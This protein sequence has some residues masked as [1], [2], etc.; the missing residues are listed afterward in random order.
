[1]QKR[2]TSNESDSL[3]RQEISGS[4]R[5]KQTGQIYLPVF[6]G[7]GLISIIHVRVMGQWIYK[8]KKSGNFIA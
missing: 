5:K 3:E 8:D 1:L 2:F 6:I 4:K 7:M